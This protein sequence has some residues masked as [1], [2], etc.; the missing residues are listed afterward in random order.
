MASLGGGAPYDISSQGN[1]V[2]LFVSRGKRDV[3]KVVQYARI[4]PL[5]RGQLYNLGFGDA[6]RDATGQ[7][8]VSDNILSQNGDVY[9][10]FQTVL[11]SLAEFLAHHP[12]DYVFVR[13]SDGRRTNLYRRFVNKHISTLSESYRFYGCYIKD[14]KIDI[15][16][17]YQVGEEY[18]GVIVCL[19]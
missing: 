4:Q 17:S 3:L 14:G 7:L 9:R 13:G 10:V 1:D 2:Y 6:T 11:Q 8:R 12:R 15:Q 5:D 19:I 16:S 18:D